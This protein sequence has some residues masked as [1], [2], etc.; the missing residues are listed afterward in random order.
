[1]NS[2]WDLTQQERASL[3]REQ[4]EAFVSVE[5]MEKGVANVKPPRLAEVP[6]V[7]LATTTYYSVSFDGDYSS[8]MCEYVF[9]TP[10]Q[11]HAFV[12]L[13]P[14]KKDSD[15]QHDRREYAKP[16][17]NGRVG[18]IELPSEADVLTVA[19]KLA[20]VKQIK[21][22]NEKASKDY[23]SARKAIDEALAG[24]W[25]DWHEQTAMASRCREIEATREEYTKMCDGNVDLADE[26]LRKV[27]AEER[28]EEAAKWAGE[29]PEEEDE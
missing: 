6:E 4:V 1:M 24:L 3:T 29:A 28:I 12:G 5:L 17:L 20:Q 14:F 8:D 13:E 27:Y 10:E 15:W 22:A 16:R 26:F 21:E 2:Y 9:K 7:S 23:Q 11:A 18:T 25:E 19:S